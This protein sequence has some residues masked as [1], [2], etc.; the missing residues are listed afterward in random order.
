MNLNNYSLPQ[1]QQLQTRITREIAKRDTSKKEA[2]L[3]QIE[4]L[5]RAAGFTLSDLLAAA[6][7]GKSKLRLAGKTPK[8]EREP[9]PAK[10]CHPADRSLTWSGRGRQPVWMATFLQNG[11]TTSALEEAA[12]KAQRQSPAKT[13]RVT[14]TSKSTTKPARAAKADNATTQVAAPETAAA[15]S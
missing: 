8:P 6:P 15:S 10:Y 9:L 14:A 3:K 13:A 4:K 2:L 5:A 1:L 12:R 11:G 7:A